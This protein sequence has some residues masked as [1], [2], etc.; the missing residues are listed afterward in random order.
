MQWWRKAMD[1]PIAQD[2]VAPSPYDRI[3]CRSRSG[4][5]GINEFALAA[6]VI[7]PSSRSCKAALQA[8]CPGYNCGLTWWL[9]THGLQV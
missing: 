1:L 2:R 7:Y 4:F 8:R 3:R 9:K 5:V 6:A